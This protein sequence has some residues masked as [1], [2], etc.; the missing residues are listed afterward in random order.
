MLSRTRSV[1]I[2]VRPDLYNFVSGNT[3]YA[4]DAETLLYQSPMR[5]TCITE[6]RR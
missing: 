4:S 6:S 3:T 5:C 2:K 1:G